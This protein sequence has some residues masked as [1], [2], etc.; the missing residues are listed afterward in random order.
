MEKMST[1]S[2]DIGFELAISARV[3][4]TI[5][6]MYIRLMDGVVDHTQEL[7]PG[8]LMADYDAQGEL[9]G[10]EV[11][12]PVKLSDLMARVSP[13]KRASFERFVKNSVPRKFLKSKAA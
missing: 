4:G 11:L 3:D 1:E 12:A 5:E 2:R 10:L 7:I 8:I 13:L 6:A 9:Y